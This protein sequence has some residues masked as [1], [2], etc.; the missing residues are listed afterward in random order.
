MRKD[1]EIREILADLKIPVLS[2][3]EA[4][5]KADIVENGTSFQENADI[6]AKTVMELT[7]QIVLADDSGLRSIT[8]TG[9]PAFTQ[10]DM[11]RKLP[12]TLKTRT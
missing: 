12:M 11:G 2:M 9:N 1:E 4:G 8:S 3:K 6:K 5:A 10:P 7:G